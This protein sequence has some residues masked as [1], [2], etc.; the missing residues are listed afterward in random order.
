MGRSETAH[1]HWSAEDLHNYLTDHRDS[2]LGAISRIWDLARR[3]GETIQ[4]ELRSAYPA[5]RRFLPRLLRTVDFTATSGVLPLTKARDFLMWLYEHP[6]KRNDD[7]VLNQAPVDFVP[8][9][10]RK[11]VSP[12]GQPIDLTMYTLCFVT[13]FHSALKA[14]EVFAPKSTQWSDPRTKLLQGSEWDG[15]RPQ[16]A[17]LLQ[18]S[19]S[20]EEELAAW[21]SDLDAAYRQLAGDLPQA[22]TIKKET[23]PHT[24]KTRD[25]LHVSGL[26]EQP[27][28]A[29]LQRLRALIAHR[30]PVTDLS[31]VV[32]EMEAR[33]HFSEEFTHIGGSPTRLG[34]FA[35]SLSAA[36]M[37]QACNLPISAVAQEYPLALAADRLIHVQ[38][39]YIRPE[40]IAQANARLV[41]YHRS[42]P[43]SALWGSGEVASADGLRFVVP[44]R[45]INAGPSSKYFGVERGVTLI[46]YT[47]NHFF[48]F[49]GAIVTGTLRDSL[50]VLDGLLEQTSPS[51]QPLEL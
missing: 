19:L 1:P 49:N 12:P 7:T 23:D 4:Q 24:G 48:G 18:R 46:N 11:Y 15:M 36:L 30:L 35:Q 45:T 26:E 32:M 44:V 14:R 9:S 5:V 40:T 43:L 8:A 41:E 10:W 17:H 6:S 21:E 22:V 31:G 2:M 42:I 13:Q 51:L 47:L 28:P 20:A 34:D 37:A 25:R 50:Y 27:D 16:V 33:T 29:S 3:P 38:Q 39:N